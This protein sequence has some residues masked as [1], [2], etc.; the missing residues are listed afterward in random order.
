MT[1]LVTGSTG[2]IGSHII[3]T[4]SEKGARVRALVRAGKNPVFPAGVETV[5]G[6]MTDL[7]S[8]R[9]ALKG[10]NTLFLLNAV[11]PDELTQAL[12]TL[13]LAVEAGIERIV[14]FSVFN[15]ALFSDVPHFTAKYNV[16]RAIEDQG[17]SATI[18]RPAYFF[19]NDA[20]L[21]EAIMNYGAYPMPL[22]NIG[23]AMVDARDIAEVAAHELL[24]REQSV[25]PL[26]RC[27][28][29]VVGPDQ[30]TGTEAASIWSEATGK[31]VNYA[32]DD[33]NAFEAMLT[34]FAPAIT[35]RDMKMMFRGFQKHGM[36]AGGSSRAVLTGLLN[37]PLR[38]YADFVR[39]TVQGWNA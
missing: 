26:P 39:E 8:M 25:V 12:V 28:I 6:D 17:I 21:K 20:T 9:E 14:Y 19:Q 13:D 36:V 33:L 10:V 22:G 38:T 18:L 7:N 27:V 34:Q 16:E 37:K 11:V 1:I 32:G 29:D 31:T 15:G 2:T 23:A 4:L 3:K 5:T 35:A 24:R 30:I